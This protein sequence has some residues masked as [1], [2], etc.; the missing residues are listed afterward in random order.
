MV[1]FSFRF[2]PSL[3]IKMAILGFHLTSPNFRLRNC[4]FFCVSIQSFINLGKTFFLISAKK[5]IVPCNI[6]LTSN[7]LESVCTGLYMY[8]NTSFI[9][10][11][12]HR[13]SFYMFV[14]LRA[15][16]IRYYLVFLAWSL[17]LF[18]FFDN[19][20]W[21]SCML[22]TKRESRSLDT[23]QVPSKAK[24]GSGE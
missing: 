10:I 1:V 13:R 3:I 22:L 5:K 6:T 17:L 15:R 9:H 23:I 21:N 4:R 14:G 19:V 2:W 7:N 12:R 20:Y 11:T 16:K 18:N 8:L 24:G